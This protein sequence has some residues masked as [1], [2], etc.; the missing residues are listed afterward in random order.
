MPEALYRLQGFRRGFRIYL[1]VFL[2]FIGTTGFLSWWLLRPGHVTLET[3]EQEFRQAQERLTAAKENVDRLWNKAMESDLANNRRVTLIGNTGQA[4]YSRW[5]ADEFSGQI[6]DKDNALQIQ[7]W[8][9]GL[10]ELL[11]NPGCRRYRFCAEV[12]HEE[13]GANGSVGIYVGYRRGTTGKVRH[14]SFVGL[15]YADR[16]G[17]AMQYLVPGSAQPHPTSNSVR[18]DLHHISQFGKEERRHYTQSLRWQYFP[19]VPLGKPSPWRKLAV[20]VTPES[21]GLFWDQKSIY[22][23][24]WKAIAS[25]SKRNLMPLPEPAKSNAQFGPSGGLGLIVRQ[26][27]ASFRRAVIEPIAE[28][29]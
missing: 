15:T 17:F 13:G 2:F 21:F 25:D 26:G 18:I 9:I 29:K 16:G 11:P 27:S 24:K 7:A 6:K 4:R 3:S 23:D 19:P 28:A 1:F 22:T 20:V 14:H 10:L 12:R 8:N 5:A